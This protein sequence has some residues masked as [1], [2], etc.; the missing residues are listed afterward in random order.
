MK[1]EGLA[2]VMLYDGSSVSIFDCIIY[3]RNLFAF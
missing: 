1:T 2:S 3:P